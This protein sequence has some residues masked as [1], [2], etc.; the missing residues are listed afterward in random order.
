MSLQSYIVTHVQMLFVTFYCIRCYV[1]LYVV[2]T[3]AIAFVGIC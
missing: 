1:S 2:E 3:N